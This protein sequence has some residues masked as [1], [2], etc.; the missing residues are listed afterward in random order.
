M[1]E[2]NSCEQ[3]KTLDFVLFGGGPL[4]QPTGDLLD[5]FC[6]VCQVYGSAEIGQVQ[7]LVPEKGDWAY[8]EP[9][10]F[11]EVDM[12]P[13]G[14]GVF[15][16]VLH[17]AEHLN[18]RR[19]LYYNF[20]HKE[21]WH[22]G[23]LFKP[24]ISKP[25]LWSFS[26]RAD[27][28]ILLSNGHKINPTAMENV[29]EEHPLI[30]AAILIGQD[31]PQP[32]LLL[33]VWDRGCELRRNELK[34]LLGP[35]V[36]KAND[37]F[38]QYGQVDWGMVLIAEPCKPFVR[39]PKG[40]V[41]RT[42]TQKLYEPEI[43]ALYSCAL[44]EANGNGPWSL[45]DYIPTSLEQLIQKS[46]H[47]L[48][49]GSLITLNDDIF[50][51]GLDSL[52][53]TVLGAVIQRDLNAH[54][55]FPPGSFST[56]MIYRYPT[57]KT[58]A[59]QVYKSLYDSQ[60]VQIS[61]SARMQSL[62]ESYTQ[63]LTEHNCTRKF[64]YIILTG[65]TGSLGQHM[66]RTLL[67]YSDVA[68]IYCLNR[69]TKAQ[70][71]AES[72]LQGRACDLSRAKFLHVNLSQPYLGLDQTTWECLVRNATI[73]I[74]T[75]WTVDFNLPLKHYEKEH[76]HGL[77][78]LIEL[79]IESRHRARLAFVSSSG[80]VSQWF[81]ENPTHSIP[82]LVPR[83]YSLAGSIG[84]WQSKLVAENILAIANEQYEIPLSILR[85]TQFAAATSAHGAE[86]WPLQ[87]WF[88]IM[89]QTS[90]TL[91]LVPTWDA[92]VDWIPVDTVA[93]IMCEIALQPDIEQ[94]PRSGSL[95]TSLGPKVY[96]VAHPYP[97]P[98]QRLAK[99]I[100]C[101]LGGTARVV[102]LRDW[103]AVL[104]QR[105]IYDLDEVAATPALK[106]LP[107]FEALTV[108]TGGGE[109][110]QGVLKTANGVAASSTMAGLR[111]LGD[112]DIDNWL[113]QCQM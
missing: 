8:L 96:N 81:S 3:A 20:P 95:A 79:C 53:A 97:I 10:P 31:K 104:K 76:L 34:D 64:R 43:E 39:S 27:D 32:I 87:E 29:V 58:L 84:Y 80:A 74:H 9:N 61:D 72:L 17:Q 89:I 88:P 13:Y 102:P 65:T 33:E 26:G 30:S 103:V 57:V 69:S 106:I 52:K 41:V 51:K 2:P 46:L 28:L 108:K 56:N 50:V 92:Y 107:F 18:H 59:F 6:D 15:E 109:G 24:H 60:K 1:Q 47:Q 36:E 73:V 11:E 14:K 22:T 83:S 90:K 5:R 23:D 110:L 101:R 38:P 86:R 35:T 25:G 94:R 42:A 16:L 12:Q 85:V 70:K 71:K 111:Q 99:A 91:D 48:L 37:L 68:T 105:K 75:S 98:W 66:L 93:Q 49:P 4:S 112:A 113:I 21:S 82:E 100:Q 67:G 19:S 55:V 62:V 54:D 78:T 63:D 7:L 40:G 77:R 44:P 45:S